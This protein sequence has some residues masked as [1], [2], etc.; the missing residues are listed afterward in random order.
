LER[1]T[2][3]AAVFQQ[4]SLLPHLTSWENCTLAPIRVKRMSKRE[5]TEIALHCLGR[6]K[7]SRRGEKGS[8]RS[9]CR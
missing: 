3:C 4:F 1:S 8:L 5:A 9:T 6:V 2:R 7:N